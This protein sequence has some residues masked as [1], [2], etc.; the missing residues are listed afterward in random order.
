MGFEILEGAT[1]VYV[2]VSPTARTAPDWP[3]R[4]YAGPSGRLDVLA[5]AALAA[6]EA[7]PG[8]VFAGVLLGPP[9]PPGI[10]LVSRACI[11][12]AASER[13]VMEVFRRLLSGKRIGGCE[14][15]WEPP[16]R[17]FHELGRRGYRVYILEEGG[18]DVSRVP[19]ALEA[20]AA[21]VAGAHLDVPPEVLSAARRYS[22]ARVSVGPRSLLVSHVIAFLGVARTARLYGEHREHHG[23]SRP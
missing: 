12:G 22:Q 8:S 23:A 2:V 4:G 13:G 21:F 19:G 9:R 17:L 3:A 20:G 18:V 11:A 15:L 16:E 14:A 10:L 7:E 1:G 5:R 6:V